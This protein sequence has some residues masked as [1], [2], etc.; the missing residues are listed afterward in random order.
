MTCLYIIFEKISARGRIF[1]KNLVWNLSLNLRTG[2][3]HWGSSHQL[4]GAIYRAKPKA[5]GS[6][7]VKFLSVFLKIK[8]DMYIIIYNHTSMEGWTHLSKNSFNSGVPC[9]KTD[10]FHFFRLVLK[11]KHPAH[12][13]VKQPHDWSPARCIFLVTSMNNG[14]IGTGATL[15]SQIWIFSSFLWVKCWW[16]S[17]I[18]SQNLS[19]S[20]NWYSYI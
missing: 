15:W 5:F 2:G 12:V 7:T 8:F 17:R 18:C 19:K 4:L 6:L 16:N 10:W 3:G 1:P 13:M 20:I 11:K 14:D 9:T